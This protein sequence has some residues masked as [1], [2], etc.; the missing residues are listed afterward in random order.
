MITAKALHNFMAISGEYQSV[1]MAT[2]LNSPP[3]ASDAANQSYDHTQQQ[4]SHC[5]GHYSANVVQDPG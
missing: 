4:Q 2:Q 3:L 1:V 5:R